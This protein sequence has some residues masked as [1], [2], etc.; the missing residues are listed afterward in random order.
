MSKTYA[1]GNEKLSYEQLSILIYIK[2]Q[3]EK[4]EFPTKQDVRD[5]FGYH[6]DMIYGK[7][8]VFTKL[9]ELGLI[10][11]ISPK[12]G[13]DILGITSKGNEFLNTLFS[14]IKDI[15]GIKKY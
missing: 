3:V 9:L 14:E 11:T 7:D 12:Q 1:H 4:Y 10:N 8:T 5:Y 2:T 13:K 6:G 15:A